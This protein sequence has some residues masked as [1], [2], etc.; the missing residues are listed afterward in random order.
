MSGSLSPTRLISNVAEK[1]NMGGLYKA[2]TGAMGG[3]YTS[4]IRELGSQIGVNPSVLGAVESTTSR[5]MSKDGLSAEYA[6]QQALEFV[7]VP[8]ILERLVPL[9]TA[10]PINTGGGGGVVTG[11]PSSITQRTQ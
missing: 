5:A 4:S 2:V 8:M 6:M 1:F 7:P 11:V 3:D 9:P 10:V